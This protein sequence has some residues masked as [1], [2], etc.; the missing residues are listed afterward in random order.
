MTGP[1]HYRE[2]ELLLTAA[3]EYD[4]EGDTQTASQ[5]RH[6]AH[7]HATLALTAAIATHAHPESTTWGQATN[8]KETP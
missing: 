2:A 1:E 7:V 5:R 8:P 6:S 3:D 4:D